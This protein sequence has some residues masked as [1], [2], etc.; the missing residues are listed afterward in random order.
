MKANYHTRQ[1][2]QD[3]VKMTQV[4]KRNRRRVWIA[5]PFSGDVS[6]N[7]D[8][9]FACMRDSLARNEA[10]WAPHAI[11]P[12]I[13]DD[14]LQEDRSLGMHLGHIWL[15]QAEL[16]AVYEDLGLSN[17]MQ[18]D[19][20]VAIQMGIPIERRTLVERAA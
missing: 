2:S 1:I 10:P 14:K 17:G 16:L 12:Q 15:E 18:E 19:I 3:P 20:H 13:L 6:R 8:Y 9:L 5:S 11:Y 4:L 7:I